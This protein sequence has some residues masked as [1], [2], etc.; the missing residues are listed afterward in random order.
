MKKKPKIEN[1]RHC[2]SVKNEILSNF[3]FLHIFLALGD[4]IP[5]M[6]PVKSAQKVYFFS[7]KISK[8]QNNAKIGQKITILTFWKISLEILL[9]QK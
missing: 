7:L 3:L 4:K 8:M 5:E 1:S 9:G 2:I 6:G